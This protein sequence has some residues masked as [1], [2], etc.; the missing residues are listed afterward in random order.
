MNVNTAAGSS[1]QDHLADAM[2]NEPWLPH[3][4]HFMY[5]IAALRGCVLNS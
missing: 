2:S 5:A 4:V 3:N 1:V